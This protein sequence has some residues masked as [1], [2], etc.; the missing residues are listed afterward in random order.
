MHGEMYERL[1]TVIETHEHA[2]TQRT[3]AALLIIQ[4]CLRCTLAHLKLCAH[5]LQASSKG[6][7]L[8]SRRP[9]P[10]A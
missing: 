6:F 10:D 8:L 3:V 5:F 9:M 7:N 4:N 2:T 1:F